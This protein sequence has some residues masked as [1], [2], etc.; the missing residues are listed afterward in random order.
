MYKL[1]L[2]KI[3]K[4]YDI[5]LEQNPHAD[6]V[7]EVLNTIIPFDNAGIFYLTSNSINLEYG[8]NIKI[9][10]DIKIDE[11]IAQE[12]FDPKKQ[13]EKDFIKNIFKL[14]TDIL[15]KKLIIKGVVIGFIIMTRNAKPFSTEEELIFNTCTKIITNLIKNLELTKIIKTQVTTLAQALTTTN[16]AYDTIKE[17]NRQI[18]K[19]EK[20]QNQFIANISHD[21]RTPLNSIIGFSELLNN[22]IF[23]KL[24]TKQ[25]E[26]V[27]DI[28]IAGVHL[29]GMINDVLDISKIESQTIKLN[30]SEIDANML[31]TEVINILN[32]LTQ[33]K[34]IIFKC[35]IKENL[36]LQ[37]DFVKLQQVL[38]NIIGNA[39]KFSPND[40]EINIL[41]DNID[42]KIQIIIQDF[43]IGIEK[44]YQKKIFEKFFQIQNDF[45]KTETSTGL[46]LPISKEFIKLHNGKI[47]V[48]SEINKGTIFT[49]ILPK[50]S[51]K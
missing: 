42:N 26:Y 37:G 15:C 16:E 9:Y 20:L 4:F 14:N 27:S 12:L 29:L 8:K 35:N 30:I 43:G 28:N 21:F 48:K 49:I 10:E 2:E 39:I 45:S 5:D 3:N 33:K 23:G 51:K 18:K 40:S 6:E 31:I 1:A 24:N 34:K 13:L 50:N 32:P 47:T 36:S 11:V 19:H 38:F 22:E 44:K 41:A 7:F 25:K 17:Q 46:G